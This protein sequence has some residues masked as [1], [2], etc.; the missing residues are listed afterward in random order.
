MAITDMYT[1]YAVNLNMTTDI[2]ITQIVDQRVSLGITR[3]LEASD[4]EVD[5]R[6]V[7]VNEQRPVIGF[8]TTDLAVALGTAGIDG[9]AIDVDTAATKGSF[10]AFFQILA[11]GGTRGGASL[12]TMLTINEGILV[13]RTL[14][15]SQGGIARL[16]YE[17][18]ATYDG[19]NDPI[20]IA[21]SQSIAA[22]TAGVT[23][24]WTLGPVSLNGTD[25]NGVMDMSIDFGIQLLVEGSDGEIWPRYVAIMSRQPTISF[26]TPDA[27][28]LNTLA[29]EGTAQGATNS[30]IYL[31][32]MDE[33]ATR[34]AEATE[35]HISITIDE[36]HLAVEDVTGA[37]GQRLG[38]RA[39]ITPTYDGTDAILVIDTTAAIT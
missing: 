38:A 32:K 26:T 27:G 1:I 3:F 22:V 16:S 23:S 33:G 34:V 17:C 31:R 24:L 4:G 20:V 12:H 7:A 25:V 13:P 10:E 2:W 36:G 29:I 11:E 39:T 35:E 14:S 30:V 18:H 28:L 6:Y 9:H 15:A 21:T 5:P 37:H 8:T 19:T